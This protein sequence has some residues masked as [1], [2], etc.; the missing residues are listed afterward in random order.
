MNLPLKRVLTIGLLFLLIPL[1]IGLVLIG[2]NR[3]KTEHKLTQESVEEPVQIV[4]SGLPSHIYAALPASSEQV[5]GIATSADA[6][7][8]I[9]EK[10]LEKY[11][12][13]MKPYNQVAQTIVAV[14]DEYGLDW[15]L[16]VA[17]AQQESNLGKKM[18]EGCNNPSMVPGGAEGAQALQNQRTR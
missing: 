17:I 13:A 3:A 14:S 11:S 15:R 6:R 8:L 10:Y 18:P 2:L 4:T 9:I 5:M 12:S 16:L 1:D 7:A